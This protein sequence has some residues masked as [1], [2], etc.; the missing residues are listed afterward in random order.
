MKKI[1]RFTHEEAADIEKLLVDEGIAFKCE[2]VNTHVGR[3]GAATEYYYIIDDNSY[4]TVIMLI[5]DYYGLAEGEGEGFFNGE[6][7]ACNATIIDSRECP[8]CGLSFA[9]S[10]WESMKEHPFYIYLKQQKL[11]SKNGSA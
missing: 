3:Y 10:P 6:C 11:L 1:P 2:A 4:K 9:Y 5:K 7:P 8:E